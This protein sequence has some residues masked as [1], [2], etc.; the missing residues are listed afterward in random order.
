MA[1]K[2]TKKTTASKTTK[3][4]KTISKLTGS[5]KPTPKP[6]VETKPA[7]E[8]PVLDKALATKESPKKETP[9][10]LIEK[11]DKLI[12][13]LTKTIQSLETK[14]NKMGFRTNQT[15]RSA[16]QLKT[17]LKPESWL[18]FG[19]LFVNGRAVREFINTIGNDTK[20]GI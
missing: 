1:T 18:F 4:T 8:N 13:T 5:V 17:V 2:A 7:I 6:T 15:I 11:K 3:T 20:P 19:N 9:K 16:E 12:G 10:K 14:L